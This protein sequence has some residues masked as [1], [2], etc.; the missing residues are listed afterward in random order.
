MKFKTLLGIMLAFSLLL[1]SCYP[2]LSVQQY[3]KLRED[4]EAL[5]VERQELRVRATALE[6]E[7][8]ALEIEL[9]DTKTR[10]QAIRAYVEFLHK[11]VS[12]QSSAKILEGEFDVESL[13]TSRDEL[14]AA[15]QELEDSE[16]VYF[17]SL[18]DPENESQT[19][20]AYY[21]I[22]EY[23]VKE[24]RLNLE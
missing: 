11:T 18:M 7:M 6:A 20:S 8:E 1:S 9:L 23:C 21:K 16:I 4:L 14:T 22:I 13:I 15:A 19:V 17:L 3:D 5:D 12:T 24:I 2:E 10:N